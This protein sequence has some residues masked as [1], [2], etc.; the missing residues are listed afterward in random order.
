MNKR[1]SW[2]INCIEYIL[3]HS[4]KTICA[5]YL[6]E[7]TNKQS[8]QFKSTLSNRTLCIQELWLL[9]HL[10]SL[11][12]SLRNMLAFLKPSDTCPRP[13]SQS[14]LNAFRSTWSHWSTWSCWLCWP[15]L[16]RPSWIQRT[17]GTN[18]RCWIHRFRP[19]TIL[20]IKVFGHA[21]AL[22][23]T[24]QQVSAVSRV[25]GATPGYQVWDPQEVRDHMEL[26]GLMALKDLLEQL[27]Q[28]VC[29][30]LLGHQEAQV[31]MS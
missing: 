6:L 26:R 20:S 3:C 17:A 23:Y 16:T 21:L 15:L 10:K 25:S 4:P 22:Q 5:E 19:H 31:G 24:H 14:K 8:R 28:R 12:M 30:A 1:K 7:I 29:Q 11:E 9:I 2:S 18:W 27:D 13:S